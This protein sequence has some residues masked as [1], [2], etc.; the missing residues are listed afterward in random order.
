MTMENNEITEIKE[1]S[2]DKEPIFFVPKRISMISDTANIL[3]WIILVG[4]VGAVISQIIGLRAQLV[5]QGI[6]IKTLLREPSLYTYIFSNMVVPL[7]TGLGFFGLLQAASLGL[8]MLLEWDYNMREA[9]NA[10]KA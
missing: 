3:S 4:F 1:S 9:K 10:G 5:S 6:A 7:L 2:E 8:S